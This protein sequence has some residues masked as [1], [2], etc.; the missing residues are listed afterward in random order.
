[1]VV[2]VPG[3]PSAASGSVDLVI[4]DRVRP[5]G[6]PMRTATQCVRRLCGPDWKS[7][8]VLV[9]HH[10]PADTCPFRPLFQTPLRFDAK[11]SALAR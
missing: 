8:E 11:Q 5:P 4:A 1:M 2:F 7:I 3:A 6:V 10:K 9:A